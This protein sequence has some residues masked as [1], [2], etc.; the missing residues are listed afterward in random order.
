MRAPIHVVATGAR[1]AVGF[2]A[3]SV[4]AAIRAAISRVAEH[5]FLLDVRGEKLVCA[6]DSRIDP[7]NLG[8]DRL[9]ILAEHALREVSS[10]LERARAQAPH[11]RF[12]VLLGLPEERPGLTARDAL[13]VQNALRACAIPG[14]SEVNTERTAVGHAGALEALRLA[15]ERVARGQ[16]QICV[17]GGVDSYFE[18]STLD[19]L[20]ADL[21]LARAEVRGGF[22]PGEGAA[23][24]AVASDDAL[25][26]FSLRSLGRVRNVSS[27]VERRSAQ[28]DEGILGEALS[29][30][31]Q[32][33]TRDLQLPGEIISDAYGDI[34]GERARSE[35]WGFALLRTASYFRDGSAYV[36]AVGQ[37]G[38]VGAATGALGC[39]LATQAWRRNYAVGSLAL[40]WAGSWGG[41]RGVA[42][43]ERP[44]GADDAIA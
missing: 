24:L 18:T 26:R 35:D 8:S 29:E 33:A 23:F 41:L 2:T 37:C 12:P 32:L 1:C 4:A 10:K 39:I 44:A 3:E 5:P 21:R 11:L 30:A 27:T 34:N 16:D 38:D 20:E 43:L 6:L 25:R 42:V 13:R 17:A 14:M 15:V 22:S 31:V 36:T 28:S 9:T 40:V 19:W 7:E